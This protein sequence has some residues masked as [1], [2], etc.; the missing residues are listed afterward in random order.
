MT[1]MSGFQ[2]LGRIGSGSA[3]TVWKA[4]DVELDRFVALKQLDASTPALRDRWR[5]EAR[6]LAELDDEHVVR[7]YGYA[8]SENTAY[9]VE[10]WV[11]G[12]TLAAVLASA[13]RL[14]GA[15]ALGVVRGAL[16]G[17][18]HVHDR[19]IVHR[20][21]TPG[22]ILVDASGASHLIDFGLATHEGAAG[23]SGSPLYRSPEAVEGAALSPASDVWSAAMVLVHL[24]VGAPPSDADVAT[25]DADL[26]PVLSTALAADPGGRYPDAGAFLAALEESASRSRG[27]AWWTEA[28]MAALVTGV[29]T[30]L[31]VE[32]ATHVTAASSATGS[33]AGGGPTTAGGSTT[34]TAVG[35]PETAGKRGGKAGGK[36]VSRV[37][38]GAGAG[39][40]AAAVVAVALLTHQG[41]PAAPVAQPVRTTS[42][43]DPAQQAAIAQAQGGAQSSPSAAFGPDDL[44]NGT[45]HLVGTWTSVPGQVWGPDGKRLTVGGAVAPAD[46]T[47]TVTCTSPTHCGGSAV[48]SNGRHY[49]VEYLG[50]GWLAIA[51]PAQAPCHKGG[52]TN[53]EIR[54]FTIR[55]P[56]SAA[57]VPATL[58][59]TLDLSLGAGC[60]KALKLG[61]D[62][63]LKRV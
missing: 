14:S 15:Q 23:S 13:G 16:L 46:L 33:A 57:T 58:P 53:T 59:A 27:A 34:H 12:A 26:R 44:M 60:G 2:V 41:P 51:D 36:G 37:W 61:A 56:S 40:A 18:A 42:G 52:G 55:A 9:I 8:E 62:M 50:I 30:S 48:S 28:G 3:G 49:T 47:F 43:V 7:V 45:F 11:D 1:T 35:T 5:A 63:T 4:R 6:T 21:V 20:D 24:L 39:V 25:V 19:G 32:G 29:G 17:L 54:A 22:N 10:E 31:V 38:V